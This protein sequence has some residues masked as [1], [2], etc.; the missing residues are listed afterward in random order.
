[1]QELERRLEDREKRLDI[2]VQNLTVSLCIPLRV[3]NNS[4]SSKRLRAE[5]E[6][7]R[8]ELEQRVEDRERRLEIEVQNVK[9]SL[10][11]L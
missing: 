6:R 8:Q 1:M 9:V 7:A 11:I 10:Y 4:N 5:A 3:H 2:E